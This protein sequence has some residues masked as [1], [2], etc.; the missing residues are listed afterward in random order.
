[1]RDRKNYRNRTLRRN[2]RE[3]ACAPQLSSV[4]NQDTT[5]RVDRATRRAASAHHAPRTE[6]FSSQV[7]LPA[8]RLPPR[9]LTT[10]RGTTPREELGT[11][12]RSL[13]FGN[14]TLRYKDVWFFARRL[15]RMVA[16]VR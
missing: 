5:T 14:L 9:K 10:W 6:Q 2:P 7:A 8:A 16:T 3:E 15:I 11:T 13:L 4:F 1:M 12:N